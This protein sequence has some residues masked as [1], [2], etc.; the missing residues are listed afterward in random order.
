MIKIN[1]T[2]NIF[3]II[4]KIKP[5]ITKSKKLV[6][7]FPFG[8]NVL[9]NK[10]ALQ[11]LKNSFPENKII[12]VTTDI[13]SKKIIKEVWIKYTLIKNTKFIENKDILKYNY[14]FFEYF[15]Y[16]LKQILNKILSII[17]KNKKNIDPRK[18][19]LK[20]YKQ[21]TNLKLLL[22]ILFIC[23]LIFL[24]I[25]IFV[26]NKTYVY[27]TPDIKIQSKVKNFI[28]KQNI[29]ENN[30]NKNDIKLNEFKKNIYLEEKVSTTWII[31]KNRYRSRWKVTFINKYQTEIKLKDKTRLLSKNGIIYKTQKW[32]KIPSATKNKAWTLIP[33]T[34]VIEVIASLRDNSWEITWSRWNTK[35]D[36]I[37]LT[38]PWLNSEDQKNIYAKVIWKINWW[39]D[40]FEKVV[41]KNDIENAKKIFT[42]NLKKEAIKQ[43]Q[44]EINTINKQSNI[45]Y[46]ILQI[47]NIYKYSN[48]D[49]YLPKINIWEKREY[50]EIKWS[51][52][53]KT[54]AFNID[55]ITSKLKKSIEENI[56]KDKEKLLY[57]YNKSI[58]IFPKI[59]VI[60]RKQNPIEIKATIE[61]EYSIEYNFEEQDNSYKEKLKQIISWMSKEKAEKRLINESK[62]SNA[63]IEIRPF[64]VD[65]VSKYLSNIEF[66]IEK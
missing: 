53:I 32:I 35:I 66:I 62:I 61:V 46:Q 12:I 20:Y 3:N 31:Q 33:W 59:W 29:D 6:L 65:K 40:K 26:L 30:L 15:I 48:I 39:E 51:I 58:S 49:I 37:L 27:I 21:K 34:K 52:D 36:N 47:D 16:E 43:I 10:V 2:D 57:I 45:K 56:L 17:L 14:S 9:Y 60:Y 54:Y 23:I 55:S 38:L 42:E 50:F 4:S 41:W 18:K 63:R 13:L 28:F 5:H 64:F 11:S 24:Y 22:I 7:E 19:F 44:K 1:K 25:F 8:H